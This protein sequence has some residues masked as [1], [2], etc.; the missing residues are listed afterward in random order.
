MGHAAVTS[1]QSAASLSSANSCNTADRRRLACGAMSQILRCLL[2]NLSTRVVHEWALKATTDRK[3]TQILLFKRR[4]HRLLIC[5]LPYGPIAQMMRFEGQNT[6]NPI[7]STEFRPTFSQHAGRGERKN[8]IEQFGARLT[9]RSDT[10]P[11]GARSATPW[12]Q[13][14]AMHR[15]PFWVPPH[16]ARCH[17]PADSC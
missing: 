13:T 14:D 8:T 1:E 15:T 4:L 9:K 6:Y 12:R 10:G 11:G 7:F 2:G 16:G 3:S 5:C 17:W